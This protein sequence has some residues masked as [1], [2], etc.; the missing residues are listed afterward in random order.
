MNQDIFEKHY[1]FMVA[2]DTLPSLDADGS[3]TMTLRC[4]KHH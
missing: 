1:K 3:Q 4:F 2:I